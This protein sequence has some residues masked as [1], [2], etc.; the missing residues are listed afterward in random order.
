MKVVAM[1]P[2]RYD[3]SRFP[4]KLL[5]PLAGK[6]IIYRTYQAVQHMN[7]F[8]KIYVVTD[9][10]E[11]QKYLEEVDVPILR[12]R[13]THECGSD[14][15][16]EFA[17]QIDADIIINVQ[18]DEPFTN[19][20]DIRRLIELFK[21]DTDKHIDLA[22]LM[23][24]LSVMSSIKNP[25]NVKVVVNKQS[26]A[27]YFSRHPIPYL[28]DQ[29]TSVDYFKHVGIYAFR[30]QALIDFYYSPKGKL[31]KAEAIEC[32]RHIENGKTIQM[33]ETDQPGIGID[34]PEDLTEAEKLWHKKRE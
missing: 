8:D 6:P 13:E 28:R 21:K 23:M 31:E 30:K 16:A 33:L 12:S 25:N 29:S 5:K 10:S 4:G 9:S 18:G 1:I 27:I 24:P 22:S 3:S 34:T 2:A 26:Q 15:L 32:I 19:K 17:H 7:L 20:A 14:R 11:I